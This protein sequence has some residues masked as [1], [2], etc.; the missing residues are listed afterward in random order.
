VDHHASD[1]LAVTVRQRPGLVGGR[2]LVQG[3][4][5]E[6]EQRVGKQRA[7]GRHQAVGA[8]GRAIV[9]AVV[10][11][12]L[13]VGVERR[14]AVAVRAH[15]AV[16]VVE[17]DRGAVM[18]VDQRDRVHVDRRAK[19]KHHVATAARRA[20]LRAT[21][22]V[23][24]HKT[25]RL[26][27]AIF[28]DATRSAAVAGAFGRV[29]VEARLVGRAELKGA[30][31]RALRVKH[32]HNRVARVRRRATDGDAVRQQLV[33]QRRTAQAGRQVGTGQQKALRGALVA[34]HI[35]ECRAQLAAVTRTKRAARVDG[36]LA[37]HRR[38]AR[39]CKKQQQ[40]HTAVNGCARF[41]CLFCVCLS[42]ASNQ[43]RFTSA[44]SSETGVYRQSS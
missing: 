28:A 18:R 22:V 32:R 39:Q 41:L 19:L 13:A 12:E 24:Q 2:V 6:A 34:R 44:G 15:G 26:R 17:L 4:L 16:L 20:R 23:R 9:I 43:I 25:L 29:V 31:R 42:K 37:A 5:L 7:V 38:A 3:E 1:R 40:K 21:A 11:D 33:I 35:T 27:T 8:V 10:D 36:R 14:R 30:A